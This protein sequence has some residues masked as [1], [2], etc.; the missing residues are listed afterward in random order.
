MIRKFV[1]DETGATAVEYA[2]LLGIIGMAAL[3]AL[4]A[5]GG[6]VSGMFSAMSG[7]LDS[8]TPK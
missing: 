8:K 3:V 6:S 4:E 5:L 7:K 2:A 1:A